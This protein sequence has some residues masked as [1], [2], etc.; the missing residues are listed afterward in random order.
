MTPGICG[1]SECTPQPAC[2]GSSSTFLAISSHSEFLSRISLILKSRQPQRV[3]FL[4]GESMPSLVA[5]AA[6]HWSFRV[7]WCTTSQLSFKDKLKWECQN[8]RNQL[9]P[10]CITTGIVVRS[11]SENV[12]MTF[13]LL[14]DLFDF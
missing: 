9:G 7:A 8:N 13:Y 6:A 12:N 3:A 14:R 5:Q 2:L 4:V 1:R 10:S 11:K